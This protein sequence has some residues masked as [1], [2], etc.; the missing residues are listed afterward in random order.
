MLNFQ[1]GRSGDLAAH[2]S[3]GPLPDEVLAIIAAGALVGSTP[4]M[5]SAYERKC[6][7]T[8]GPHCHGIAEGATFASNRN[9]RVET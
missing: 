1:I 5:L 7:L 2:T 4:G 9:Y 3:D 8:V 6:S